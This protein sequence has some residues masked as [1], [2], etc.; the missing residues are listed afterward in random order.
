MK[1]RRTNDLRGDQVD[2]IRLRDTWDYLYDHR[3]QL[4]PEQQTT[5]RHYRV[6]IKA[7]NRLDESQAQILYDIRR[8][9]EPPKVLVIREGRRR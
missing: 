4:T 7:G 6:Y 1:K 9:L 8:S 5:I 3:E 2:R